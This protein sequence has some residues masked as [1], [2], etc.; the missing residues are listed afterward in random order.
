MP[1]FIPSLQRPAPCTPPAPLLQGRWPNLERWFTAMETRPAYLGF[2]S[3]YYTHCHDLPPQLGGAL[4]MRGTVQRGGHAG[5]HRP[6]CVHDR[7]QGAVGSH[8]TS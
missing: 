7:A 6:R 2:K 3:D 5:M 4:R 8:S 1:R